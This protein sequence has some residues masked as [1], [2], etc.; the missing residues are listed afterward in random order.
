MLSTCHSSQPPIPKNCAHCCTCLSLRILIPDYNKNI[1]FASVLKL[2]SQWPRFIDASFE[3]VN[4]LFELLMIQD[5]VWNFGYNIEASEI[6]NRE[7][8]T[9]IIDHVCTA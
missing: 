3:K 9:L 2:A 5:G 6:L 4:F 1:D 8:L 7:E